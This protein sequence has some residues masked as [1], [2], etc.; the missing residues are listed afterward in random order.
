MVTSKDV[1]WS[2][3]ALEIC[4]IG[5]RICGQLSPPAGAG[6]KEQK[7]SDL[8]VAILGPEAVE[9]STKGDR[10]SARLSD[11]YA[12]AFVLLLGVSGEIMAHGDFLPRQQR[13]PS[14]ATHAPAMCPFRR[15]HVHLPSTQ[16]YAPN[17]TMMHTGFDWGPYP[18]Q[19]FVEPGSRQTLAAIA[20]ESSVT[21]STV[22]ADSTLST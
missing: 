8:A 14:T 6:A 15:I 22:P 18:C 7:H 16:R 13:S 1:L 21:R 19:W 17:P 20:V 11:G 3:S 4:I 12:I 2:P 5:R 9:D 10:A